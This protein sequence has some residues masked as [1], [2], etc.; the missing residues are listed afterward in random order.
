MAPTRKQR[1]ILCTLY[2]QLKLKQR[3]NRSFWAKKWLLERSRINHTTLLEELRLYPD[4]FTNFLRMAEE[5]YLELFSI[6][7]PVLKKQDTVLRQ[8]ISSHERLTATLRFLATGCSYE[9]LKFST[10]ISP[11]A[12]GQIIPETCQQIF[13]SLSREYLKVSTVHI[14]LSTVKYFIINIIIII[15]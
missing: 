11:Q 6:L 5:N 7:D 9:D 4:D 3:K 2:I 15:K 8:S 10:R 1:L 14:Y 12:L 13:Q